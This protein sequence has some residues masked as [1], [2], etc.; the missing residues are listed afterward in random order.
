M[1]TALTQIAIHAALDVV[2]PLLPPVFLAQLAY[3]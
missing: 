2:G 1:N 3:V